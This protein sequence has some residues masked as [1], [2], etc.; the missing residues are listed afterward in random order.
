[1]SCSKDPD[2]F[3]FCINHRPGQHKHIVLSEKKVQESLKTSPP[4]GFTCADQ[5]AVVVQRSQVW[6]R[7]REESVQFGQV[8]AE[9]RP[10]QHRADDDVPQRMADEAAGGG[11][12]ILEMKLSRFQ[13]KLGLG[14]GDET[15][16]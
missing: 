12:A 2:F 13:H 8:A 5:R 4:P 11:R 1:M 9:A 7:Q 15:F 16:F 14:R 3:S 10:R 6:P